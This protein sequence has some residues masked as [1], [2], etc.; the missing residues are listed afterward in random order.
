ML[1][2]LF[3]GMQLLNKLVPVLKGDLLTTFALQKIVALAKDPMFRVRKAIAFAM[4]GASEQ[5]D[6]EKVDNEI[7]C[8]YGSISLV[9][10]IVHSPDSHFLRFFSPSSLPFFR[11]LSSLN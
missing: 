3:L 9:E 7:V 4:V 2:V 1:I 6:Q 5:L 11:C 10:E 8:T